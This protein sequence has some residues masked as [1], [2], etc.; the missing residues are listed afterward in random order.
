MITVT[1]DTLEFV[2]TLKQA[3]IPE[4]QA[5]GAI[6]GTQESS[7]YRSCDQTGHAKYGTDNQSRLI[8]AAKSEIVKWNMGTLLV[9][10][11]IFA[12]ISKFMH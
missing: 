3:G 9:A 12:A 6:R 5:R 8:E 7:A 10:I 1:F 4:I 2:E 11:G